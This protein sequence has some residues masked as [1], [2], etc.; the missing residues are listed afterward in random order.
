MPVTGRKPKEEHRH[1][2]KPSHEW[3]EV[4]NVP[5]TKAPRLPLGYTW[6]EPTKKWWKA[7]TALPHC[8][9]WDEGDWTFATAT[10]FIHAQMWLGDAA[11]A[12]EVR[13]RERAMGTTW[14]ARRDLRIKYVDSLEPDLAIVSEFNDYLKRTS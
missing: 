14:D 2:V 1:R 8:A 13:L 6:P 9:L 3:L 5:F 7:V 12:A 4:L 10:A 11:R